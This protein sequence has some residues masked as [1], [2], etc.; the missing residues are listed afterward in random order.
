MCRKQDSM[1]RASKYISRDELTR[2]GYLPTYLR[3]CLPLLYFFGDQHHKMHAQEQSQ[4]WTQRTAMPTACGLRFNFPFSL[5]DRG[6]RA[7]YQFQRRQ[8]RPWL[9]WV[10]RSAHVRQPWT[11]P[12][13]L[14]GCRCRRLSPH[15]QHWPR[16]RARANCSSMLL[17]LHSGRGCRTGCSQVGGWSDRSLRIGIGSWFWFGQVRLPSVCPK[18][19][20]GICCQPDSIYAVSCGIRI[21]RPILLFFK[22]SRYVRQ[23]HI[24][25]INIT[26]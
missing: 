1:W 25:S 19:S 24:L 12:L 23:V 22:K 3:T 16:D 9:G 13:S 2:H 17:L 4:N 18:F 20:A 26:Y 8:G 10:I 14:A 15:E 21:R 11:E 7:P 5:Q 6:R